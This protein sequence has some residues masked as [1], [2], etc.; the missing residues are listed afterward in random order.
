M[1]YTIGK[2]VKHKHMVANGSRC[3]FYVWFCYE[4]MIF[5]NEKCR[6]IIKFPKKWGFFSYSPKLIP[7]KIILHLIAKMKT[8]KICRPF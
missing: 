4:M 5:K 8:R 7:M 3:G 1:Y 2:N 6:V